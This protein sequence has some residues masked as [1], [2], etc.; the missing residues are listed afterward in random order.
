MKK[1]MDQCP[2]TWTAGSGRVA[3][4]GCKITLLETKANGEADYLFYSKDNKDDKGDVLEARPEECGAEAF[5]FVQYVCVLN[6]T[7]VVKQIFGLLVGCTTVFIY[8]FVI[9]FIDYIKTVEKNNYLDFDVK[10]I[11]AEDY[12]VEFELD[13][14]LFENW[15][16]KYLDESNPMSE[17]AQFKV[18][19]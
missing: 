3:N 9:V 18:Y 5:A 12:T 11:T 4:A 13:K 19:V 17:M 8:F 10:T 6:D 15:Q 7:R 14:Q 16:G 2:A 1:Q